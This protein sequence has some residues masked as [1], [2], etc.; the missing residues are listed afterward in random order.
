MDDRK[1]IDFGFLKIWNFD[2][3]KDRYIKNEEMREKVEGMLRMYKSG[4]KEGK[5]SI[6]GI[7]IASIGKNDFRTLNESEEGKLK[8]VRLILFL[9]SISINNTGKTDVN[10]GHSMVTADNFD[11]VF[12]NFNLKDGYVS[13]TSGSI[14]TFMTGGYEISE[15]EI[16]KPNFVPSPMRFFIDDKLLDAFLKLRKSNPFVFKRIISS[17]E[18]FAEAYF[19]SHHLSQKARILLQASAFEIFFKF[20]K[21][22][23]KVKPFKNRI[24]S[25]TK[26]YREEKFETYYRNANGKRIK[27]E[28]TRKGIWAQKF[29]ELR[30]G[31]IHGD[32][33]NN[34][35]F[36]KQR[37]LD[38]ALLFFIVCIKKRIEKYIDSYEAECEIRW[39]KWEDKLT[40]PS[41][42]K[43]EGF[44]IDNFPYRYF[45]KLI[46]D[47]KK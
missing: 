32:S 38:I 14:V 21:N 10:S 44:V 4:Y 36:E 11:L 6:K 8:I 35:L 37:H 22:G 47:M 19:N 2:K 27:E 15:I 41:P 30:S 24:E 28:R 34:F 13:E 29:Y 7:G 26:L 1:E 23:T 20:P 12:Q 39:E 17:V 42:T 46:S 3:E 43:K 25:L 45:N 16:K 31:I 18:V 33:K 40:Y 5:H 9:C